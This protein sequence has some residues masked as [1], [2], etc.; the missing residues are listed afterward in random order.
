MFSIC[1]IAAKFICKIRTFKSLKFSAW[2]LFAFSGQSLYKS[3]KFIIYGPRNCTFVGLINGLISGT[4]NLQGGLISGPR[5]CP[6]LTVSVAINLQ[7]VPGLF[8][9][10]DI[11]NMLLFKA[12]EIFKMVNR[13]NLLLCQ[14][15]S[16]L[17]FG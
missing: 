12:S 1:H 15:Q 8:M 3:S 16:R 14:S 5:N 11:V 4:I 13:V 2:T 6:K 10:P 7:N 9:E 17:I